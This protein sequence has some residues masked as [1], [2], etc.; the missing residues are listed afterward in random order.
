MNIQ[1]VSTLVNIG[2]K[3]VN[4]LITK[5]ID[6]L[7]RMCFDFK[8]GGWQLCRY[9]CKVDIICTVCVI[10]SRESLERKPQGGT[11]PVESVWDTVW[12]DID[13]VKASCW[14]P[15]LEVID[16]FWIDLRFH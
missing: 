10:E 3:L 15:A 6:I 12:Q 1:Q 16:M 9:R 7:W 5:E 4:L 2:S 13:C 11:D 14:L 8:N